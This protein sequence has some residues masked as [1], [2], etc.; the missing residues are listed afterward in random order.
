MMNIDKFIRALPLALFAFVAACG[1]S[2]SES[3]D[4]PFG[5]GSG[6][7]TGGSGGGTTNTANVLTVGVLDANGNPMSPPTLAGPQNVTAVATILTSAGTPI[8]NELVTFSGTGL[9]FTPSSATQLTDANG[10]ARVQ[11][12][13]ADPLSAGATTL[14]ATSS[15]GLTN[16]VN[17]AL[18][19]ST[20]S[21]GALRAAATTVGAYENVQVTVPVTLTG[22]T[23]PAVQ[24]P[25][26]FSASCGV[27]DPA[28]ALT[29]STGTASTTFKNQIGAGACS[30]TVTLTAQVGTT[31]TT[32]TVTA[33]APTAANIQFVGA[34]PAR[35]YLAGSPGVSQ[36]SVTFKLVDASGNPVAGQ[37]IGLRLNQ[38]PAG[39]Y[40]GS[41]AGTT[42][43]EQSTDAQGLVAV[44]VNAGN[45]PGPVQVEATLV[46][47]SAIRNV[48]NA[49]AVASGLPVQ[50]AFALSVS[51][52]NIEA[53]N[54]DGVTTDITLRIADRLGNPVPD[55]T[56]VNF[57][58]EGGQVVASC[59]TTGA[60]SNSTAA[61]TVKLSSQN[62]R[63][64]N[65]RI[66][67]LAWAQGEETFVDAGAV[68]NNTYDPGETFF[69]LGQPFLDVNENDI[70]E[71]GSDV[72]VAAPPGS[73][74][75]SGAYKSV[76]GTCDGVWGRGLVRESAVIV[77]SG[78]RPTVSFAP[79]ITTG[80]RCAVAFTLRD[81]NG[82]PMPA[83]TTLA[84]GDIGGGGDLDNN[85]RP[86]PATAAGFG[87][88]GNPVPNTNDP[89]R[90]THSAVFTKCTRPSD[91]SFSLSVT[92]PA[93]IATKIFYP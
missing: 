28:Q 55:G 20:A 66:S 80:D 83:G 92:T 32:T 71:A 30:G 12:R 77:F 23:T 87:G 53:L 8:A 1:G 56:T 75:C 3:G 14:V 22:S 76:S 7:G 18:S 64:A 21:L 17:V 31:T 81:I 29:D 45:Q 73:A 2:G 37:P 49:L 78:S 50:K 59:N 42:V 44:A 84:I 62:P 52:F 46:A 79:V 63:P 5:S 24:F 16:R 36:A 6:S 68:T 19:A 13:S 65:G 57:I 82:N 61:C 67:V 85:L 91:L 60:S 43:L 38:F 40:L 88:E 35:I 47:N 11:V 26:S 90:T 4:S 33:R 89:A 41:T 25:V 74:A 54:V 15:S 58:S 86:T 34:N 10:V 51:T 72:T 48:S 70:Y 27:F 9:T 39:V 69:D 93:G